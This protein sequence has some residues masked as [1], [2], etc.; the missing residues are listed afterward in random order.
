MRRRWLIAL[1]S[2]IM[3]FGVVPA[4]GAEDSGESLV[5]EGYN[6]HTESSEIYLT[7]ST[8]NDTTVIFTFPSEIRGSK[9]VG[10]WVYFL[11][12]DGTSESFAHIA[13][14]K[15]DGSA[16]TYV[17][18]DADYMDFQIVGD[19][20]YFSKRKKD[21]DVDA[22]VSFGSMKMDGTDEKIIQI[23]SHLKVAGI[24]KLFVIHKGYI[25][26]ADRN[27]GK[28]YR[29]KLDGTGTKV[30][31]SGYVDSIEIYGDILFFAEHGSKNDKG[32][33]VDLKSTKRKV[34]LSDSHIEPLRYDNNKFYYLIWGSTENYI[35][36]FDRYSG[37][38]NKLFSLRKDDYFL[39]NFG[40]DFVF[41]S[42]SRG[43]AFKVGYNGKIKNKYW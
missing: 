3:L 8:S 5:W 18:K 35:Y 25:Y 15:K 22:P 34:F 31:S 33:L 27:N 7:A 14:I 10:E 32:V 6:P 4:Y 17:S 37:K 20:I 39:G 28:L 9:L 11:L 41:E 24:K 16:F 40:E 42:Y 2:V 43:F 12:L 29:M 21:M 30:I 23:N 1:L 38:K 13:K 26:Y 36:V 19:T